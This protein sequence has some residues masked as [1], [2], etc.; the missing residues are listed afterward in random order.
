LTADSSPAHV[1]AS[2]EGSL[3]R[4]GVGMHDRVA[5]L[6]WNGFRHFEIYYA[7][8]GS[9]AVIHTINPRLFADQIAY[10][11]N[12]AEDKVVFYD[13]TFAALV[14]KL[15]PHL[16]S[17][18][19]FIALNDE[20]ERLLDKETDQLEWPSFD[21][22]TAACLCYT[23]GTTGNPKGALYSHRSTA[24]HSMVANNAD[25]FGLL[26]KQLGQQPKNRFV[27]P[28]HH[29][30]RVERTETTPSVTE[31]TAP[32]SVTVTANSVPLTVATSIR[33]RLGVAAPRTCCDPA[34]VEETKWAA[35]RGRR[36]ASRR[37]A[38]GYCCVR[39][40]A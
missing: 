20:Y 17:V 16:K 8:A 28:E 11:A 32:L 5:T 23:S 6:A 21:E 29:H 10:I 26:K 31:T 34:G 1:R 4:L 27:F 35:N 36:S 2:V 37:S 38:P 14:E 25:A 18:R 15:K 3:K 12:H 13:T 33:P 7:V 19:H 24:I 30:A 22:K 39:P 40:P 9:G